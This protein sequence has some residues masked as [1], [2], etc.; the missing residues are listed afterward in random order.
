MDVGQQ[1]Q[2]EGV[3][4]ETRLEEF[5]GKSSTYLPWVVEFA[6]NS[7]FFFFF[8]LLSLLGMLM[9]VFYLVDSI[10]RGSRFLS[11]RVHYM[12]EVPGNTYDPYCGE[13]TQ[14]H[15]SSLFLVF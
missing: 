13:D 3:R 7:R 5:S 6:E 9:V 11:P 15:A 10:R 1:A 8:V 12:V 14:C 2:N 4:G